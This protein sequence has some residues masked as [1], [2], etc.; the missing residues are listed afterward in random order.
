MKIKYLIL[1]LPSILVFVIISSAFICSET[2]A[3]HN[4]T[5]P[6]DEKTNCE[7]VEH[8]NPHYTIEQ[9]NP[10][11]EIEISAHIIKGSPHPPTGYEVERLASAIPLTSA[12]ALPGFPSYSWV[13]G[14]GAVS[15]AMIAAY[16]DRNGFPNMYT[17][18]TNGGLMPLT[19]TAWPTW[20]D[21]AGASYPNNPLV[22]SKKGV[23]GRLTRGTIDNYWISLQNREPDPFITN[24]WP[25]HAWGSAIGD[26]IKT[27][28]YKSGNYDGQSVV[29][30]F[31]NASTKLTCD[32]MENFVCKRCNGQ[33]SSECD[34]TYGRKLFYEASGYTVSEC[35]NQVTDNIVDGGFSY[36]DFKAE[37]DAGHP[38]LIQVAG[39]FMVGYGYSGNDIL[40]RDTWDNDPSNT[41]SMPWGGSYQGMEM[42]SVGI[43][44]PEPAENQAPTNILLSNNQV[45]EGRPVN[46]LV[47]TFSTIDPNLGDTHTY[48]LVPGTGDTDNGAFI[49]QGSQL[50]TAQVFDVTVKDSYDI[51]V[52][53]TD[54]GGL[55]Y[56]KSF[57]ILINPTSTQQP[58]Y[59]PLILRP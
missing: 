46:T 17:G 22:A 48:S 20:V 58:V 43:V 4:E 36:L 19:D 47:G 28:Q 6:G 14:C 59:L 35:Y 29:Y 50:L 8:I 52:R 26:Y 34:I 25:Q 45:T 16:Y 10:G 49:I 40:I 13:Y 2:Y 27:S 31:S 37:I 53:S 55:S 3:F 42:R 41:Y 15:A 5:L 18:P 39:H 44:R 7:V 30:L 33:P 11:H 1:F 54:Q 9:C 51:R 56:E 12:T 38:V 24:S 32:A 21:S 23:D 57:T